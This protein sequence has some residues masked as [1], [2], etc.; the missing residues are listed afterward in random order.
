MFKCRSG[1]VT[2]LLKLFCGS[3]FTQG[4]SQQ[5]SWSAPG[6][7]TPCISP[8]TFLS[9]LSSLLQS[10]IPWRPRT[11]SHPRP[12]HSGSFPRLPCGHFH[13]NVCF[14]LSEISFHPLFNTLMPSQE[15]GSLLPALLYFL[16]LWHLLYS[17]TLNVCQFRFNIGLR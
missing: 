10:H 17:Q 15:R 11:Q 13:T 9:L 4:Q 8:P 16:F 2:H 7:R 12:V 5:V 1:G 14:F 3:S 6:P